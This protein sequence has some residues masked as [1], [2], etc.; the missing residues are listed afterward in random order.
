VSVTVHPS[1]DRKRKGIASRVLGARTLTLAALIATGAGTGCAPMTAPALTLTSATAPPDFATAMTR[2]RAA[3]DRA[4][5]LLAPAPA[6]LAASSD[7]AIAGTLRQWATSRRDASQDAHRSYTE[8]LH[9]AN[10]PTEE[11]EAYAEL[12]EL[13]MRTEE[14][15]RSALFAATPAEYRD[16][17][18]LVSALQGAT[19]YALRPLL[20]RVES[21]LGACQHVLRE[22]ASSAPGSSADAAR[23]CA[24]VARRLEDAS[25]PRGPSAM[26]EVA[27]T[28]ALAPAAPRPILPTT[29]PKPCTFKGTLLARGAV[30]ASETG[31]AVV[32]ALNPSSA[33]EVESLA[34]PTAPGGRYKVIVSWPIAAEGYLETEDGPFVLT[35]RVVLPSDATWAAEGER[36]EASDARGP[37]VRVARPKHATADPDV[38]TASGIAEAADRRLFCHDLELAIPPGTQAP[39]DRSR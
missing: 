23:I 2:A 6:D 12:A 11:A 34:V 33:I 36:V 14:D 3:R 18:L 25:D 28:P 5:L 35:R 19:V 21:H 30:Y 31:G 15:T 26:R 17:P 22:I 24:S 10:E 39:P 20:D 13:W 8:A 27:A 16:N 37:T 29:H 7:E 9:S 1:F 4:A 38:T 32:L